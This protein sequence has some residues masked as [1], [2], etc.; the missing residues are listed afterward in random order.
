MVPSLETG[1]ALCDRRTGN[2]GCQDLWGISIVLMTR[3]TQSPIRLIRSGLGLEAHLGGPWTSKF[4]YLHR[5]L[6]TVRSSATSD[7]SVPVATIDFAS[8]MTNDI[9]RVGVNYKFN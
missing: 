9:L 7:A 8:R 3:V 1:Q 5:D 6:G 2:R 4:E